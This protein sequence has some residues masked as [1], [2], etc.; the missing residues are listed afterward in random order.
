MHVLAKQLKKPSKDDPEDLSPYEEPYTDQ[1]L[2]WLGDALVSWWPQDLPTADRLFTL[3]I[4]YTGCRRTE[5]SRLDWTAIKSDQV[6]L[7]K[8]IT[9]NNRVHRLPIT[10]QMRAILDAAKKLGDSRVFPVTYDGKFVPDSVR[11]SLA[12][13]RVCDPL[14]DFY[15]FYPQHR[16]RHTMGSTLYDEFGYG[17]HVISQ[18]LNH[19][20]KG[21][22]TAHYSKK[23]SSLD[24][25]AEALQRYG[26]Y[27]EGVFRSE[28]LITLLSTSN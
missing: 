17:E 18:I 14:P 25:R 19:K 12:R 3:W 24:T 22:I 5:T 11:S 26:D 8:E 10:T 27:L 16:W 20:R 7:P 9:K 15:K 2:R 23:P 1:Q 6:V 21:S 13:L 28:N 4:A